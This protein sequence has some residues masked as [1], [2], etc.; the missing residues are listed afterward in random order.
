MKKFNLTVLRAAGFTSLMAAFLIVAPMP[1]EGS[2]DP[3]KSIRKTLMTRTNGICRSALENWF[4]SIRG[5][6]DE[7]VRALVTDCFMG[8]ARLA[9]LGEASELSLQDLSLTEVPSALLAKESGMKLDP[10][11]PLA[12]RVLETRQ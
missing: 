11:R 10:Y 2:D 5:M 8:H 6:T 1:V 12:G 4:L 3:N 9:V 7:N